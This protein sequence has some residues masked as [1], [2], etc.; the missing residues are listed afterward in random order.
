MLAII[1]FFFWCFF[2]IEAWGLPMLAGSFT[3][4]SF[5]WSGG[6]ITE[7][8]PDLIG[9]LLLG[10]GVILIS[11]RIFNHR[12]T[13]IVGPALMIG[14]LYAKPTTFIPVFVTAGFTVLIVYLL[15]FRWKIGHANLN[16]SNLQRAALISALLL[17]PFAAAFKLLNYYVIA[18]GDSFNDTAMLIEAHTGFLFHAPDNVKQQFPQFKAVDEYADLMKL[19]KAEMA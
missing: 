2:G 1:P 5:A 16:R 18:A 10:T 6:L 4:Y 13:L 7:F 17:I 14:S 9:G 15:S 19:I 11:Q 8:R 3:T 12:G